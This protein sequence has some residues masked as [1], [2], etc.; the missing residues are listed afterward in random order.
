LGLDICD[1]LADGDL[2]AHWT[3]YRASEINL[4]SLALLATL[5]QLA[6]AGLDA[7][8]VTREAMQAALARGLLR[9]IGG[10][11]R[12]VSAAGTAD[13]SAAEVEET[14]AAK[15]GEELAIFATLAAQLAGAVPE[16]IERYA[17]LGRTLGT[18]AQLV[19]D[20]YDVFSEP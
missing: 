15:S 1:D 2:P 10:Q 17:A 11:Q 18:G 3:G 12:D 9:M 16:V 19:Y 5:P 13:V 4:V 14:V 20:C 7:P 6:I 8:A